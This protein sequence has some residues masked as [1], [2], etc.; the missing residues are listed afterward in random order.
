M[1]LVAQKILDYCISNQMA[2][3]VW[4]FAYQEIVSS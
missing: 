1:S 4:T 3:T 2:I